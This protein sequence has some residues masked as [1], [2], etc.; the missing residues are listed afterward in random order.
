MSNEALGCSGKRSE[1]VNAVYVCLFMFLFL[2]THVHATCSTASHDPGNLATEG[3]STLWY[4][5]TKKRG[6]TGKVAEA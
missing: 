6:P 5:E 4:R 2:P 1:C 3:S